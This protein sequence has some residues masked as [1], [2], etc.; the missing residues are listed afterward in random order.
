MPP[1]ITQCPIHDG[2]RLSVLVVVGLFFLGTLIDAL[3]ELLGRLAQ[4]S[5]ESGELGAAEQQDHDGQDDQ[6]VRPSDV[7]EH[8]GHDDLSCTRRLRAVSGYDR[9]SARRSALL[10]AYVLWPEAI[11]SR[12]AIR[13]SIGGCVSK[14]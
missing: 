5:S 6:Q 11:L 14:R 9:W 3:A 2:P 4:R 12:I 10:T 8:C 13:W 7:G 1:W